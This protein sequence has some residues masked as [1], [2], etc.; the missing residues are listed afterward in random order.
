MLRLIK[1]PYRKFRLLYYKGV[2]GGVFSNIV[3]F[4]NILNGLMNPRKVLSDYFF[5][6]KHIKNLA[7]MK[8]SDLKESY[9]GQKIPKIFHFIYMYKNKEISF[10]EA[11]SVLSAQHFNKG[12]KIIFHCYEKPIGPFASLLPKD[13]IFNYVENFDFYK[14][15]QI[16]HAAH[17]ADILRLISLQE[18]GGI[19]LDL[20]TICVKSFSELRNFPAAMGIQAATEASAPKLCN[21][22]IISSMESDFIKKW[23]NEYKFFR[24]KGRD[25]LWDFHSGVIPFRIYIKNDKLVEILEH[26]AFFFPLWHDLSRMLL[27]E[28]SM[29]YSKHFQSNFCF[30]LWNEFTKE[31]LKKIT[32]EWINTSKSYYAHISKEVLGT[33]SSGKENKK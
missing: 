18:T 20:D 12:W 31:D 10:S 4:R 19:Y 7:E 24:S 22:V 1:Y 9:D 14:F 17:K 30:H 15:S 6:R 8:I 3:Y 29:K 33:S 28:N 27:E 21:A 25:I 13:I 11:I 5:F 2:R 23:L 16:H 32:P 26:D